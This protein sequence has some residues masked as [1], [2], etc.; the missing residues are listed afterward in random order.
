V[1]GNIQ[2][3]PS[4]KL[5]AVYR[6]VLSL[7]SERTCPVPTDF[8]CGGFLAD[9]RI[10]FTGHRLPFKF[11]IQVRHPDCSVEDAWHLGNGFSYAWD[12]CPQAGL[13]GVQ[14]VP[15]WPKSEIMETHLVSYPGHATARQWKWDALA[16]MGG[17]ILADS[18]KAICSGIKDGKAFHAACWSTRTG[19]KIVDDAR[20]TRTD[21]QQFNASGGTLLAV[22]VSQWA[23][24]NSRFWQVL[25]MDGCASRESRR[26]LWNVETGQEV[27]S[28]PVQRQ[29]ISVVGRKQSSLFAIALSPSGRYLAEGGM[30]RVQLYDV[31]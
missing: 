29:Q 4:G 30:G 3:S 20:L 27:V 26:V 31:Q 25:D 15:T 1:R 5:L 6:K 24:R 8:E 23:C 19:E 7:D 10:V 13:I 16:T 28:W 12:T 18:C 11:E 22:T 9:D 17:M 21:E 2:W 14:N